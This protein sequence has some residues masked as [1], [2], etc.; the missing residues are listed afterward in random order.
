[1]NFSY[2]RLQPWLAGLAVGAKSRNR[3]REA[4]FDCIAGLWV[5]FP[6]LLFGID[7]PFFQES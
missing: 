3:Q 5:C 2:R 6:S 4:I 1:M 7:S